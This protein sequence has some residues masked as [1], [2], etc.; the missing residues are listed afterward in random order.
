MRAKYGSEHAATYNKHPVHQSLLERLGQ[1]IQARK[2]WIGVDFLNDDDDDAA[3][4]A[5][6]PASKKPI[7]MLDYA[8][9]SGTMSMDR[10]QSNGGAALQVLGPYVSELRGIDVSAQMVRAYNARAANQGLPPSE[11]FAYAGDLLEP[12]ESIGGADLYGFDLVVVGLGLHHLADARLAMERLGRR[13]T[14]DGS[15]VLLVV[16]FLPHGLVPGGGGGGGDGDCGETVACGGFGEAEMVALMRRA[17]CREVRYVVLGKGVTCS[18]E[19]KKLERT[20]FMC[21]GRKASRDEPVV[22][23]QLLM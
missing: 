6:A 19:G 16:D 2:E 8:C 5:T 12:T 9:G 11:M 18:P 14:D 15:G 7:R 10:F 17:G 21:R 23:D 1:E 3:T 4:T 20:V 13:L 22:L